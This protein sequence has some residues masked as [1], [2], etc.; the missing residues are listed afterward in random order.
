MQKTKII[1]TL[2]PASSDKATMGELIANGMNVARFNFS[3]G[4]HEEQVGKL[5][6]FRE[7]SSELNLPLATLLDTKGPEI[8]LCTFKEGK[9]MLTAGSIFT[10]TTRVLEGDESI[11]SVSYDNMPQ[12][13]EVGGRILLD[14]GL[15]ELQVKE[16]VNGTDIRCLVMN[17]GKISNKKG[18]NVPGVHLSMA[19]LSEKDTADIIF[20]VENDFDYIA[21]SFVRTAQ[22]VLDIR[23][24][25]IQHGGRQIKIIAKI[26]NAEGVENLDEILNY[27]DGIMVAR[28]DLGVEIDL[29]EIPI[30]QK[31]MIRKSRSR[32]KTVIIATQMLE[33]MQNNPRPTRAEASDVA[34]AIYDGASAIMLS[35]ETAAGQYP[36]EAVKTMSAIASR[37]ESVI[38]YKKRFHN[39]TDPGSPSLSITDAISYATCSTAHDLGAAAIVACTESGRSARMISKYHPDVPI[40][41]CTNN[42]VTY[43]QLNLN[44]GVTP[45]MIDRC[46]STDALFDT[47]V[48]VSQQACEFLTNGELVVLTAGVPVGMSGTTNL[49]KVQTLGTSMVSGTGLNGYKARGTICVA[50]TNEELFANFN[51]GDII[52]CPDTCDLWMKM[53]AHAK[54]II[55]E[56]GENSHVATVADQLQIPI[57]QAATDCCSILKNGMKV[58]MDAKSG[59]V[60]L[61]EK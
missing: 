28:G 57:I 38:D 15:I 22:D 21:A 33:T 44:W 13:V 19:Y 4:G 56:A 17:S 3:H 41:A 29:Q 12:D 30:L 7:L 46:T 5:A 42:P 61:G 25:L 10:L 48:E 6:T 47:A 18:V 49:M 20:G 36:V 52:V 9:V 60:S 58:R 59:R 45:L 35:G 11:V 50:R 24:L 34:N 27:A 39:N 26:E 32:G 51:F 53:I 31:M 54:G 8:R 43:R 16:I 37:V 40:V 1:C 2:G 23:H 14:D 55:V